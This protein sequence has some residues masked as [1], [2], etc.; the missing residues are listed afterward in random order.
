MDYSAI[1]KVKTAMMHT[2]I[3]KVNGAVGSGAIFRAG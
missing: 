2:S 3:Q 1:L